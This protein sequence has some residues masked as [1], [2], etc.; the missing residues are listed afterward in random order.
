MDPPDLV[1]NSLSEL[2]NKFLFKGKTYMLSK[3]VKEV[4]SWLGTESPIVIARVLGTS[5]D[6][7]SLQVRLS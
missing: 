5:P 7:S 4:R 1:N 2:P 3:V 6:S